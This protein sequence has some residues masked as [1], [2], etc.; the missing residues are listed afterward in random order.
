[1]V[2][3]DAGADDQVVEPDPHTVVADHLLGVVIDPHHRRAPEPYALMPGAEEAQRV[4]DV[5]GVQTTGGDLIEQ[6]LEGVVRMAVE[7]GDPEPL[8]GQLGG[9]RES[10]E[11]CANHDDMRHLSHGDIQAVPSDALTVTHAIRGHTPEAT[12]TE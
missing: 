12:V 6:R 7:E 3:G 4:G 2:G 1:V 10:G 9:R 8:L 5:A 11:A